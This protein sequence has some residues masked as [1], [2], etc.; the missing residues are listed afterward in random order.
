MRFTYLFV[1]SLMHF[2]ARERHNISYKF[3]SEPNSKSTVGGHTL[4]KPQEHDT[5]PTGVFLVM[6]ALRTKEEFG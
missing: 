4:W 1:V 3:N 5:H 2:G 6:L